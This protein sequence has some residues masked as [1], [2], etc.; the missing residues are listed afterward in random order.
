MYEIT[1]TFAY[2]IVPYWTVFSVRKYSLIITASYS[3]LE[4]RAENLLKYRMFIYESK[5]VYINHY[6][7]MSAMISFL[8]S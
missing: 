2:L 7:R 5:A 8:A 3:E 6:V 4:E 1:T